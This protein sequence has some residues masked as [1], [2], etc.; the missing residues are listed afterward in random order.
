M[1]NTPVNEL[2]RWVHD[3]KQNVW[4]ILKF[5]IKYASCAPAITETLRQQYEPMAF[6]VFK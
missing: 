2:V 4:S 1:G 3:E 6:I 5:L